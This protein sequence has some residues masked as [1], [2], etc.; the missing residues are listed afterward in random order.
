MKILITGGA[1]F[2]GSHLAEY[3]LKEGNEVTVV[4]NLITGKESNIAHLGANHK[5]KFIKADI[6]DRI[7]IDE[8]MNILLHFA[9]PASPIDYL[10]Y[11]IETVRTSSIGTLNALAFVFK[12]NSNFLL[13]STSEVYGDPLVHPQKEEYWGNVNP[14]GPR[15]VYDESKRFAEAAT[16]AYHRCYGINTH[17]A[18]IFNTYGSRMR[19][20][21][22]RVVPTFIVKALKNEPLPIFGDGNQTRSFC[23]IDDLVAGLVSLLKSDF[24]EP[25]NLGNPSE[26]K[27]IDFAHLIKELTQSTSSLTY[28]PLPEDDPKRRCPDISRAEK[29]LGWKPRVQLSEGIKI[30][31]AWF[32]T[33]LNDKGQRT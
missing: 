32:R 15:S 9:S 11:P 23:F 24:H 12:H 6:A 2:I 22:G 16:M 4:D 27:V 20:D 8:K 21:D 29:I 33:Y 26:F 18:R 30:S 13:A 25:V 31:I 10:K 28:H 7:P 1:G 19:E 5:F 3:F 17:I 14:I